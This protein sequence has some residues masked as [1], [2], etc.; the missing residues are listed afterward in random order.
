MKDIHTSTTRLEERLKDE[1]DGVR[2]PFPVRKSRNVVARHITSTLP[3]LW[4]D[5]FASDCEYHT[6]L[7]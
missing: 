2:S 3:L 1:P 5:S 4:T 6:S 7:V